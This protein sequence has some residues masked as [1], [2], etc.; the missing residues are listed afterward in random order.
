MILTMTVTEN[1]LYPTVQYKVISVSPWTVAFWRLSD[2]QSS[3]SGPSE[4][5]SGSELVEDSSS[6]IHHIDDSRH[7][8]G[9]T[10]GLS[11]ELNPA[12]CSGDFGQVVL[13]KARRN[14]TDHEKFML[15]TKHFVPPHSYKFPAHFVS[16]RNRH[17]Q[18]SWLE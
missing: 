1:N 17:F 9:D 7:G 4:S 15:L 8:S 11:T 13:L 10:L 12:V 14:L 16:G 6:S 2:S 18:H 5:E 3:S